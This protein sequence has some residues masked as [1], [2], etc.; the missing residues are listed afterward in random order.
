MGV[1]Q[2][3]P[4]LVWKKRIKKNHCRCFFKSKMV[5]L[6]TQRSWNNMTTNPNFL[7]TIFF[8]GNHTN[9][10]FKKNNS[11]ILK[12]KSL[13]IKSLKTNWVPY[14]VTPKKQRQ[15]PRRLFKRP[16]IHPTSP[17]IAARNL[18]STLQQGAAAR[19]CLRWPFGR[20]NGNCSP[21]FVRGENF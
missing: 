18:R 9:Y 7:G 19:C 1:T 5:L 16:S 17:G 12:I 11:N 13:K 21:K 14:W 4:V 6:K 20:Q 2:I 10:M 15:N 8:C 3:S